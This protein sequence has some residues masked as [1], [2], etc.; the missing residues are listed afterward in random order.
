MFPLSC[1]RVRAHTSFTGSALRKVVR[2]QDFHIKL[3]LLIAEI[4]WLVIN[5]SCKNRTA[6]FAINF[7]WDC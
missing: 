4:D 2:T 7:Y 1:A 6:L 3:N 5:K